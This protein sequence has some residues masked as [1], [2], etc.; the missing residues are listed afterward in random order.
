MT[1]ALQPTAL[2][3]A[4]GRPVSSRTWRRFRQHKL[5]IFGAASIVLLSLACAVLPPV[6][7][8]DDLHIDIRHRFGL[9]IASWPHVLGTDQLGRDLLARVLM[10]GRI[11]LSVGF[12]AMTIS[13]VIGVLVGAV[14]GFYQ[15]FVGA[16]LM[17]LVDAVLCF[18]VIF[19]LLTLAAL[20]S[21][22]IPV[23]TAIIAATAWMEVA[24]V[25]EGQISSLRRRDFALAAE[26]IGA[27]DVYIIVRELLPNAAG[28]ILVAATLNVARAI[29]LESYISFLGFG[30]QAPMASW[31]NMLN[32]AQQYLDTA[33]WLAILP[34]LMITLAVT[35]FNFLGDGL[36]DALDPVSEAS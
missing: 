29:L 34:G 33:P 3:E 10:A 4:G 30:I 19:L 13:T 18:P 14:A 11:S 24:R 23:I 9:P 32:N 2:S 36:R 28:P 27:S 21:P 25:V 15:G 8:F 35:S 7:P 12:L 22:S 20:A 17:R 6:L 1:S 5:A 16:V 31:G 26:A